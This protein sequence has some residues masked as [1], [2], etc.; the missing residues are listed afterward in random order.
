MFSA[1]EYDWKQAAVVVSISGKERR[2]NAG[3]GESIRL[4][5]R[6]L[7]NAEKTM[8]NN[9]STGIY[10]DGSGSS[11][12]QIGGLQ[13]LV[14]DDPDSGTVGGI[15]KASFAFWNNNTYDLSDNSVTLSNTTVQGAMNALWLQC[16]RGS[17]KPDT[18]VMGTTHFGFFWGSMQVIQRIASTT[19]AESGFQTLAYYGP[20]GRADVFH[21][22][23]VLATRS[24]FL[25]T[26]YLFWRV[27]RDANMEPLTDRESINQDATVVPLIFMGNLTA[28]NLDVQG[29]MIE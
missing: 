18:I 2:M 26:D 11:S 20:G 15:A 10:S 13:L 4:L 12:K 5:A 9:I 27:H 23:A 17:D 25:N 21:D 6:R 14:S 7:D 29:V 22:D 19:E 28:S 3:K 8:K 24:Y 1:A 16:V